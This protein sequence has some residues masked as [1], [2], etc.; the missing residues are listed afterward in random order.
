MEL[1]FQIRSW[2]YAIRPLPS[3]DLVDSDLK[4]AWTL[5]ANARLEQ[6]LA[7]MQYHQASRRNDS[8]GKRARPLV[9]CMETKGYGE[10]TRGRVMNLFKRRIK[11][12]IVVC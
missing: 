11:I 5:L 4:L 1:S 2:S 9:A 10:E 6:G 7:S 12:S 3:F 8:A